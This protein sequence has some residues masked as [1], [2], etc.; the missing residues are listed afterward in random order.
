VAVR[1]GAEA[2]AGTIVWRH[3]ADFDDLMVR[4]PLGQGIAEITRR[5]GRYTLT[6]ADDQRISAPDPEVLT[7]QALGWRLPLAGLPDWVRGRPYPHAPSEMREGPDARPREI[8]QLGWTIEYLAYDAAAGLPS[9]LRLRRDGLEIRLTID[10]WIR[11]P[12]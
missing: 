4:S 8:H 7:E 3:G 10:S 1:S 11:A 6:T 9:R 2:A 12:Q 5:A